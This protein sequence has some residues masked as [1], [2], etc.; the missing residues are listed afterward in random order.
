MNFFTSHFSTVF[1]FLLK[2]ER[3]LLE[4]DNPNLKK[5]FFQ[6]LPCMLPDSAQCHFD[7]G[8]RECQS[9]GIV[10]KLL[11]SLYKQTVFKVCLKRL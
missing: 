10:P 6:G 5:I 2:V 4:K 3:T 11:E 9:C 7:N 1:S 8:P